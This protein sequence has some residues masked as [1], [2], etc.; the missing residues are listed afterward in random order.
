MSK[1]DRIGRLGRGDPSVALISA[2]TIFNHWPEDLY[3]RLIAEGKQRPL[4][5]NAARVEPQLGSPA[6]GGLPATLARP[7]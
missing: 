4:L 7:L 2:M 5:L 3:K 1:N 6:R